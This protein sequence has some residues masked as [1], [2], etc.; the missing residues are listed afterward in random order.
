MH[1]RTTEQ[2]SVMCYP[3]KKSERDKITSEINAAI[4]R[5]EINVRL[6]I[7]K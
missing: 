2:R 3:V 7:E 1:L 4:E 6:H 5:S